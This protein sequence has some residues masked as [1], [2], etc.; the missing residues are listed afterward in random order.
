M[1]A[2]ILLTVEPNSETKVYELIAKL[3]EVMKSHILF[4][5]WDIISEVQVENVSKLNEFIID[6][7]RKI[8]EVTMTS[9]MIVAK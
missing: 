4:G 2:Y 7:I 5:S 6:K 1:K 9:T 8:P 3:Q